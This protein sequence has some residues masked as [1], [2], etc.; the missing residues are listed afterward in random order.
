MPNQY[1]NKIVL[2]DPDGNADEVLMDISGDTATADDVLEG[3]TLHLASGAPATGTYRPSDEIEARLES[4]VGHSSKNLMPITLESG[5]YT[6]GGANLTY[7]VDKAAGTITLNGTSRTSGVIVLTV[8]EDSAG[9]IAGNFYIS[10][11]GNENARF[12]GRDL[13]AGTGMYAWDGVTPSAA[14]IGENDS[15]QIRPIA[16]HD[17]DFRYRILAG[18]TFNNVVLKPMLRDGSISDDTFEP[19]VTPTDERIVALEARVAALEAA[20]NR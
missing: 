12:T 19:Y 17:N 18:A 20:L 1:N 11:G 9:K 10:G 4:T 5:T 2:T 14:S 6:S 15:Q 16:G 13:T 7:T 8:Y 3:R